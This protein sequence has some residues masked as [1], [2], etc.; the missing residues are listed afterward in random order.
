[1][2]PSAPISE[3]NFPISTQLIPISA[4]CLFLPY[5]MGMNALGMIEKKF[6]RTLLGERGLPQRSLCKSHLDGHVLAS[7]ACI[8]TSTRTTSHAKTH[9]P[10]WFI[11]QDQLTSHDFADPVMNPIMDLQHVVQHMQCQRPAKYLT[12]WCDNFFLTP[13]AFC[14]FLCWG[15]R[16]GEAR[17]PFL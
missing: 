13:L 10:P 16:P 7:A 2:Q 11:N 17:P 8:I 1:M 9:A 15:A 5:E 4:R 12:T 3:I 6:L 14:I